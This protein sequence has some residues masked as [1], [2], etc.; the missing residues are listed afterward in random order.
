MCI[1]Y[2]SV[3]ACTLFEKGVYKLNK[4]SSSFCFAVS[5]MEPEIGDRVLILRPAWLDLILAGDKTMEIRGASLRPGKYFLGCKK[6][7]L[8]VAHLGRPRRITTTE[9][10]GE[11]RPLHCVMSN[12]LPYKKTFG[13]PIESLHRVSAAIPFA[14]PRGAISIV[15]YRPP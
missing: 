12:E 4:A 2:D 11:L 3:R 8:A 6:R 10:W 1:F 5:A 7:I 9:E 15:K 13:L 14:H